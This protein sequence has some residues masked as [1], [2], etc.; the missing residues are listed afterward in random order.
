M[1]AIVWMSRKNGLK[2]SEVA[3]SLL[4]SARTL[5][6][7]TGREMSVPSMS[8]TAYFALASHA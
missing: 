4:R 1:A 3:V 5:S 6:H 2:S 7:S 8:K